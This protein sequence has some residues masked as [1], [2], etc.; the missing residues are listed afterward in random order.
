M[1]FL[2]IRL[3]L[4]IF[5]IVNADKGEVQQKLLGYIEFVIQGEFFEVRI[6]TVE[7]IQTLKGFLDHLSKQ[8]KDDPSNIDIIQ[9]LRK[10]LEPFKDESSLCEPTKCVLEN[11]PASL[12][13]SPYSNESN[14]YINFIGNIIKYTRII[15]SLLKTCSSH[16]EE[17]DNSEIFSQVNEFIGFLHLKQISLIV[18]S[19]NIEIM[20]KQAG[21]KPKQEGINPYSRHE[22]QGVEHLKLSPI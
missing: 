12:K 10:R 7:Q 1:Y 4:F 6:N 20:N 22:L 15:S 17:L 18:E 16:Y 2:L 9:I 3:V 13:I 14:D 5:P 8:I 11:I 19:M 21:I